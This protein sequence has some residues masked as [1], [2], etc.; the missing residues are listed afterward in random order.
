MNSN[1][2]SVRD[3]INSL[4]IIQSF[5][6][7]DIKV[8]SFPISVLNK[9]NIPNFKIKY[10]F[11]IITSSNSIEIFL[12]YIALYKK[13]FNSSPKIFVI[14]SETAKKLNK[15][16]FYS[17]FQ[18]FGNTNSLLKT[19]LFNT[20]LYDKGLWLC[21]RNRNSQ[22]KDNL[23]Y[24][25]RFLSISVVYEMKPKEMMSK[26]LI[27]N[28]QISKKNIFIVSSSRNVEL[29]TKLLNKNK[30][31]EKLKNDSVLVTIS[32]TIYDKAVE[33]GWENVKIIFQ[34]SR[35]LFLNEFDL[36]IKNNNWK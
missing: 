17:Y 36:L 19:I 12:R 33:S 15:K 22:I 4:Q 21:G 30:L 9:K 20:S 13:K 1:I 25:K 31:F 14:G 11:I 23:F 18:A 27:E 24:Y 3:N 16:R 7:K 8:I 10:D 28:L 34:T 35:K 2:Y 29:L 26:K 5:E 6:K 32:K